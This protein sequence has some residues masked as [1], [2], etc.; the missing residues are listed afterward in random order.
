MH[1]A[2]PVRMTL[3]A[4]AGS[5][6]IVIPIACAAAANFGAWLALWLLASG[7][8]AAISALLA[9]ALAACLVVPL[10]RRRRAALSGAMV[11][12]GATWQWWPQTGQPSPGAVQVMIDLGG[13]M[14]LRFTP[15]APDAQVAWLPAARRDGPA[16]WPAWRAALYAH[17]PGSSVAA[18]SEPR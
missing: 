5:Q 12:D 8:V 6:R 1:A 14:L 17:G 10:L 9:A 4:P 18:V 3:A 16:Q 7:L 2:P 11:W 13:W 15:T